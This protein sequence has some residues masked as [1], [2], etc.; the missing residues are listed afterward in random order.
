[1]MTTVSDV[2]NDNTKVLD[3]FIFGSVSL[4]FSAKLNVLID[5]QSL[6]M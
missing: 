2:N 5:L 4:C 6:Y 3:E 1:M